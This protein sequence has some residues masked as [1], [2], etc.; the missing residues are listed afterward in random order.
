MLVNIVA[1]NFNSSDETIEMLRSINSSINSTMNVKIYIVDNDSS[2]EEKYKLEKID[3]N[4]VCVFKLDKNVGYFP[5]LNVGIGLIPECEKN[6]GYTVVCNN[7]L[8]FSKEF[9]SNLSTKE[10]Q[11]DIFAV[12]P[13]V[14]TVNDVYQNPSLVHKPSRFR[15]NMY[16][17]FYTNYYIGMA[18][19][20]LWRLMGLGI[21]SQYRKDLVAKEIFIGIGAIYVLT[22]SFFKN[23]IE[24]DYPLFLY[25]E[26]AFLSQQIS[27]SN[28]IQW[29]DPSLEVVH[30]ESVS[31]KK[32]PSKDNYLL[33]AKAFNLY[34]DYFKQ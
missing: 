32:I 26:E 29:Y 7:D 33:N 22:P 30:L 18:I 3:Y 16:R 12:C 20:K 21:D 10:Y 31:T 24:L 2:S 25:G 23:N 28:G 13:S 15:Y 19:L 34:R 8:L 27:R 5:A 11:S 17:L 1:V 9:F 14:K 6:E 4:N